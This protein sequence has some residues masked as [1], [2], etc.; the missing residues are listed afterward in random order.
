MSQDISA[1]EHVA[2]LLIY[3]LEL[4]HHR[5]EKNGRI[6]KYHNIIVCPNCLRQHIVDYTAV[7]LKRNDIGLAYKCEI[8]GCNGSFWMYDL[9]LVASRKPRLE[10]V[11]KEN[12][13][14]LLGKKGG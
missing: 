12:W 14:R 10:H 3:A 11:A 9:F 6:Y 2:A 1:D 8:C 13:Q 7:V 5:L 4:E